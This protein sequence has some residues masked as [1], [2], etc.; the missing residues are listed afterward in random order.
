[1]TPSPFPKHPPHHPPVRVHEQVHGIRPCQG[2]AAAARVYG[3]DPAT[4]LPASE[5]PCASTGRSRPGKRRLRALNLAALVAALAGL[6]AAKP[7]APP[8]G[9]Q[10]QEPSPR[11]LAY[12][13][14]RFR[15]Q[16]DGRRDPFL[17]TAELGNPSG[18]ASAPSPPA[19]LLGIIHHPD[20]SDLGVAL[21]AGP[22]AT[23]RPRG[24]PAIRLR[25]GQTS[26]GVRL[27]QILADHVVIEA[28]G[29]EG[30]LRRAIHLPEAFRDGSPR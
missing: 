3:V 18:P 17:P 13:R 30:A 2:G 15:Y 8:P 10:P 9:D 5:Q 27:A 7:Q 11:A 20:R 22:D 4:A 21:L 24:M 25:I 16:R 26:A 28:P 29:S 12:E 6:L 23:A 1:M 19:R 14:E